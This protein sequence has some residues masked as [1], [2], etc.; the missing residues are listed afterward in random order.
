MGELAMRL[1][2]TM[3][4]VTKMKVIHNQDEQRDKEIVKQDEQLEMDRAAFTRSAIGS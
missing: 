4:R 2:T 3:T 1:T